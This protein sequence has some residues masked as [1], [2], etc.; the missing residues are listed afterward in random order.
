[1]KIRTFLLIAYLLCSFTSYSNHI[2]GGDLTY[3]CLGDNNYEITLIVYRDCSGQTTDFDSAPQ[4]L[5]GTLTIFRNGD[6]HEVVN[7]PRPI[8]TLVDVDNGIHPCPSELNLC[9]QKG[10]YVFNYDFGQDQESIYTLSYQRCCRNGTISSIF[11]SLKV[12]ITFTVDISPEARE[13]CNESPSFNNITS[14]LSLIH[15]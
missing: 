1:M 15:I 8:V 7:L 9:I 10:R 2:I 14:P 6:V 11:E 12:G 5:R 13:L 3:R 4:S